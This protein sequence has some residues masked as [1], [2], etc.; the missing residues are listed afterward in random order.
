M[1]DLVNFSSVLITLGRWKRNPKTVGQ[2][3]PGRPPLAVDVG[4]V[5]AGLQGGEGSPKE[6]LGKGQRCDKASIM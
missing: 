4:A 2:R 6:V 1:W 3:S 5:E